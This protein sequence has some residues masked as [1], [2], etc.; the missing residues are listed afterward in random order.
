MEPSFLHNYT[1]ST[2]GP[3][4]FYEITVND[5]ATEKGCRGK[6]TDAQIKGADFPLQVLRCD[7]FCITTPFS[8]M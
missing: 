8:E 7:F 3:G 5:L 2:N 4:S 6:A 1:D